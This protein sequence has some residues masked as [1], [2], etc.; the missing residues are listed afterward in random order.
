MYKPISHFIHVM[1][2]VLTNVSGV[3]TF[4][5]HS[6]KSGLVY[7]D[8]IKPFTSP[9]YRCRT[10]TVKFDRLAES[11]TAILCQMKEKQESEN[12]GRCFGRS[13]APCSKHPWWPRPP[14]YRS[15]HGCRHGSFW[16]T[17]YC[18]LCPTP[19]VWIV[20]DRELA[21]ARAIEDVRHSQS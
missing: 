1:P 4:L 10:E 18:L 19:N 13:L 17:R 8:I 21:C 2:S 9:F 14:L 16:N 20:C 12:P 7:L 3:W 11:R 5:W 6:W 15:S